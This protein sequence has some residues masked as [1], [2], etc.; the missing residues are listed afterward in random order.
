MSI[1]NEQLTFESAASDVRRAFLGQRAER[2]LLFGGFQLYKF[3][4]YALFKPDGSVTPWWSSVA[5]LAVG[6]P[7]LEGT[8]ERAQKIGA[9]VQQF[10]RARTAVTNQWNALSG[11]LRARLVLPVYGFAGRCAGQ[12]FDQ[13]LALANVIYIGGAWQLWIPN[14]TRKEVNWDRF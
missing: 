2:R 11:T 6:D 3:T 7:G 8:L 14:L 1:L 4:Q 5:P 12:P 9:N 10:V 13:D